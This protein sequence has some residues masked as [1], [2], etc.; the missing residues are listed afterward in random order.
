MAFYTILFHAACS[1]ARQPV[2][3]AAK[4]A[5]NTLATAN[6]KENAKAQDEK[7]RHDCSY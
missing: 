4:N 1:A 2:F 5:E 7:K 3:C 6:G